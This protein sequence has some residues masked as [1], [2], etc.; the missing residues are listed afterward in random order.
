MPN[1][2][3]QVTGDY[4]KWCMGCDFIEFNLSTPDIQGE[5]DVVGIN[6]KK[7]HL[8][9]CEV[10]VHLETGMNYVKNAKNDN[11]ERLITKFTKDIDYALKYFKD[12]KIR[13][14]LWSPIVRDSRPGAKD[15]QTK[16]ANQIVNDIN[17]KYKNDHIELELIVNE[18][19][20]VSLKMSP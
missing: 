5:I 11:V 10:V 13:A 18:T 9:V 1:T 2:G 20:C 12:H 14:M 6:T 16:D 15:N 8:F 3:E 17:T 7:K 4:L 19:R